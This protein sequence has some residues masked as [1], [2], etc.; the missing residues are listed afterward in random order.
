MLYN[1]INCA[2]YMAYNIICQQVFC[3]KNDYSTNWI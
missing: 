1:I 3:K 2:Y